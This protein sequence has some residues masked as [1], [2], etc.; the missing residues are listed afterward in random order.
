MSPAQAPI[1]ATTQQHL[2]IE[3]I[4]DDLVILKDGSCCLVCQTAAVNFDLL[5][6]AEQEATIFAYASLLNSLSSPIQI[7]VRSQRKDVS[8]YLNLLATQ[9]RKVL[10]A[11]LKK[12]IRSYRNFVEKTVREKEVLDKKF[13]IVIPFSSLEMGPASV[14]AQARKKG[15]PYSMEIILEKAKTAL[16]PKRDH[17]VRQFSRLGLELKQLNAQDLIKLFYNIYNQEATGF[18][19]FVSSAEYKAPVMTETKK[20]KERRVLMDK[21]QDVSQSPQ[22]EQPTGQGP[23]PPVSSPGGGE[24]KPPSPGTPPPVGPTPGTPPPEPSP[25]TTPADEKPEEPTEPG[26]TEGPGP[27]VPGTEEKA[28][29]DDS[30]GKPAPTG[31]AQPDDSS[32]DTLDQDE[33]KPTSEAQ[34]AIEGAL[35]G[36]K[37]EA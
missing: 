1:K 36:I 23:V 31:Q 29:P 24:Q 33:T 3:E 13:Y 19:E 28:R 6:E 30:S 20:I 11:K 5:S 21:P 4:K 16:F 35:K 15:L 2:D 27:T 17:L 12:Q 22:G 26:A 14:I 8:G 9:E 7:L 32:P 10:G 25:P 18:E 37:T 34:K